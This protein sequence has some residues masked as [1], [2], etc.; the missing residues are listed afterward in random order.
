MYMLN[1]KRDECDLNQITKLNNDSRQIQTL[2]T[3]E[4]T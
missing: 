1:E 2:P 3:Q 4:E